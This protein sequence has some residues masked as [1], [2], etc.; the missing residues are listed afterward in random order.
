LIINIKLK[1]IVMKNNKIKGL[2]ISMYLWISL[3][4]FLPVSVQAQCLNLDFSLANFTYWQPYTGSCSGTP[5]INTSPVT[6][7]RHTIMNAA[8]LISANQMRDGECDSINKVPPGFN[9]SAKLGNNGTGA[10]MEALEYTMTIDSANSLLIL[11]F[12]W[13]MEDPNHTPAQQPKFS[14][15]IKD[16]MGNKMPSIKCSDVSFVASKNLTNLVCNKYSYGTGLVARNWTTVGFSL[17][18]W[19]GQKI[20]IYFETRD[21]TQSGH[22][23]YAYM[24][25]EC[26]PMAIDIMFCDYQDTA[27]LSAPDGFVT[28]KW[29]RSSQPAWAKEGSKELC[30]NLVIDDPVDGEEFTCELMSELGNDCISTL[31]A[32]IARTSVNANFLY[33]I[34]EN[35]EVI[36][37]TDS[38][39]W[40]DTCTRT[41]TFVDLSSVKNSQKESIIWEIPSLNAVSADSLFT[42][43]F[44]APDTIVEHLVRLT[45]STKNGCMDTM[46]QYITIYPF[47]VMDTVENIVLCAGENQTINF[48]GTDVDS[49]SS[50]WTNSNVAIGL[51]ASGMG[52]ISFTPT[53]TGIDPLIATITMTPINRYGCTG[54]SKTFIITVSSSPVMDHVK[55]IILC[56]GENQIINFSGVNMD[57]DSFIWT[58][59]NTAIGL[60]TSGTGNISFTAI[61]TGITPLISTITMTP[62]NG[63]CIGELETF[64]ITV[65]PLPV[66]DTVE[67]IILCV[68]ENQII[69]FTG[70][71][72]DN[73]SSVWTNDNTAIGLIES[74]VGDIS[75][76]AANKEST[77]LTAT[78]QMTPKSSNGCIGTSKSVTVTVNPDIRIR[79]IAN[80]SLFC[81]GNDIEFKVLN[82]D[83]LNNIQWTGP[84][85]FSSSIPNPTILNVSTNNSG[86][87]FM[88]ATTHYNC[89]AVLDSLFISVLSDIILDME[90]TFFICN[91]ETLIYSN[92]KNATQ[93]LWN[94]GDITENIVISSVGEYWV[95]ATNQR[96]LATDTVFVVETRIPDF[97]IQ[98]IGDLCQDGSMELYTDIDMENLFYKW[99]T[100]DTSKY[101]SIFQNGVYGVI[102]S[103]KGCT[104]LQ[105]I[106]IECPCDLWAP[107]VFTPNGDN[108]NDSFL[109]VPMSAINTFSMS[110]YDRW[111]SLIYKTDTYS[112]WD[113]TVNGI[114][115]TMGV[116]AYVVYYSCSNNPGVQQKKQGKVS[117]IR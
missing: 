82:Q 111:G 30:Q 109:L 93:Y 115:A 41:A 22:F 90:D 96:C 94:T 53:N 113:G 46:E 110:I 21:C 4:C 66:I 78:I 17:E 11:H 73:N 16:S 1:F 15:T 50:T 101:I 60:D 86:M 107:D 29:K 14:M 112:P 108:L 106:N 81:E 43:T 12:A 13:V 58:N 59:S 117:L 5:N 20:K 18:P 38:T 44:P 52:N 8:Q 103:F 91:S 2:L 42:Y 3:L 95:R 92:A 36:I 23:G 104:T 27:Y 97:E 10:E 77:P 89:E 100:G 57:L 37:G 6:L 116:Y 74:G 45:V 19:I 68:G 47:P 98:T 48:T 102:V 65:N 7:N 87:Y 88:N 105:H 85:S 71:N 31:R 63:G 49:N 25:G 39:N 28:Y 32:V 84:D 56:A 64:T 69:N 79:I 54:E 33:G 76:T 72:V 26:R 40:Y 35:G 55:D 61:N 114:Y 51:G 62:K 70:I 83:E 67:N 99:T 9:Y 75:F 34:M 80:D 24:V